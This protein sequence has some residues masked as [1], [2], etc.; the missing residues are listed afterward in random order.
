MGQATAVK[1]IG[2]KAV[3]S[4]ATNGVMRLYRAGEAHVTVA[5]GSLNNGAGLP[6][7]VKPGAFKSFGVTPSP[8]EPQAGQS[9]EA[10]LAAWDEFHN[11]LT[12]YT[13][14]RKLLYSGAE[15]APSGK[16]PEYSSTTEP[17]FSAGEA[18]LT[19]FHFYK[20]ATTT[21]KVTEEGTGHEGSASFTVKAAPAKTLS[22]AAA[23][24]EVGS[25]VP[26]NLT[27]TAL[28]EFQNVATSYG[29]GGGE[30]KNLTFEG[31]GVAP[32]GSEATVAN[33]SGTA[34]KFTQPTAIRF[35]AGKASVSGTA[36]GVMTLYKVE[37]AHIKVKEG[38]LN[39]GT[40]L[41]IKVIAGPAK[42]L[43]LAAPAPAEPEAGQAFNVTITALDAGGN[44]A[45]SYGGAG[46]QNKTLAYSGPAS[47]PSGKAPEY[48]GSATTVNFRE[49]VGTATA[50]KL[51]HSGANTLTAKEG[52]IEGSVAFN[53]KAGAAAS[54]SLSFNPAE[55]LVGVGDELTIRALDAYGNVATSYANGAHS[56]TFRGPA[57]GLNGPRP[58]MID[59]TGRQRHLGNRTSI[60]FTAG[61]A[62]VTAG[63]NGVMM[64]FRAEE[65]HI[66]V[67]SGR[68]S[69]G[70]NGQAIKVGVGT[71]AELR[72]LRARTRRTGSRTGLQRHADRARRR[73]RR[74][75]EL[76]RRRGPEQD[77]RILRTRSLAL[78][79]GARIPRLGHH[80]ELP[81]RGRHRDRH[82]AL[83]GRR[84]HAER[85]RRRD[86]GAGRL[87]RKDRCVQGL[88][89]H[90]GAR[91]TAGGPGIQR[92]HHRV[93]SIREPD[94]QLH[95][96]APP[97]LRRRRKLRERPGAGILHEHP[98]D[99][100][101]R[102]GDASPASASTSP[103]P[104]R[105]K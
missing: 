85:Q 15:A 62:T 73:R 40:G 57:N 24:T 74:G 75:D 67:T 90:A 96:H 35:V 48:P 79:Q 66:R 7:T 31:A 23:A 72:R 102:P 29:A 6:I 38:T 20:A 63:R 42:S 12:T 69:N 83:P 19:G 84:N 17:T 1:F 39:N 55:A 88:R 80:R 95:A 51:Y 9:F 76:R 105:S 59:R 30:T 21:L 36:N 97:A 68:L 46:G 53:V 33:E 81:R 61:E 43:R 27:I 41:A 11:V 2:G 14:T 34:T 93:G 4:G 45:T 94:H 28:D 16:A 44:I 78:R 103:A 71:R 77:D 54:L 56:L 25:G 37:E 100:R 99:L 26:D 92:D 5:E 47:S 3:V 13:R 82:Q 89:R 91:R 87:Q 86:H 8:A 60:N 98:A 32:S 65:A 52:T 18:T 49:G 104:P 64:L 50:I 70:T 22:L 58:Y 101:R 10:K